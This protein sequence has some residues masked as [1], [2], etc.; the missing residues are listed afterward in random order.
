MF[1]R[2]GRIDQDPEMNAYNDDLAG[3]DEG[4]DSATDD[5]GD[6]VQTKGVNAQPEE[7]EEEEENEWQTGPLEE[8]AREQITERQPETGPRTRAATRRGRAS[9]SGAL[10]SKRRRKVGSPLT[11]PR[12]RV[13]LTTRFR[14]KRSRFWRKNL[15]LPLL[16]LNNQV[17]H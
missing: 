8:D 2:Y 15:N 16:S 10:A 6:P 14:R 3:F 17:P 1:R 7:E 4:R 12:C 13:R 11:F 5:E 9:P